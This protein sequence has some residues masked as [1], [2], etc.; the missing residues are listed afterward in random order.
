MRSLLVLSLLLL[1]CGDDDAMTPM[2]GGGGDAAA[3]STD[4]ACDDGLFCNGLETCA[5]GVCAPGDAPC[6]GACD[7]AAE[8][9]SDCADADG[10]GHADAAC[11]GD[12]CDDTDLNRYPGNEEVCD[13]DDVDEDCDPT[14]FGRRD[15]DGDDST[16]DACCNEGHCG[17]DCDDNRAGIS[18]T[19][20]ETCNGLDDDCDG[21]VDE[22]VGNTFYEDRDGDGF[23]AAGGLTSMECFPPDG[24][25]DND[26]DCND[27]ESGINPGVGEACDAAMVDENC[28]DIINPPSLCACTPGDEPR[29]CEREGVCAMG[30]EMCLGGM[31]GECSIRPMAE[32]CDGLDNDCNG[33]VDDGFL[34]SDDETRDCVVCGQAGVQTCRPGCA[35]FGA[36]EAT[37]LCND[38]DDDSDGAIDEDFDCRVGTTSACTNTCGNA[39]TALCGGACTAGACTAA[40]S[41]DYC[42]DDAD[43]TTDDETAL[44]T[45]EGV[46]DPRVCADFGVSGDATCSGSPVSSSIALVEPGDD[47]GA[48][49]IDDPQALGYREYDFEFQ[50]SLETSFT[51]GQHPRGGVAYMLSDEPTVRGNRFGTTANSGLPNRRGVAVEHQFHPGGSAT[52]RVRVLNLDGRGGVD[53]VIGCAISS[54]TFR[55]DQ[56]E[57]VSMNVRMRYTPANSALGRTQATLALFACNASVDSSCAP[58]TRLGCEGVGVTDFGPDTDLWAGVTAG[59]TSN[60]PYATYHSAAATMT[61]AGRCE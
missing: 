24:F 22:G 34:C 49:W 6:A 2:D 56:G 17:D 52:D 26:E 55:V 35:G 41:C 43:G 28:D 1:A 51:P 21:A 32:T 25:A 4:M 19:G 10:D 9:C 11:G 40:E 47:V 42:D 16:S 27:D 3:C 20:T 46:H 45:L 58:T 59:F 7:E 53:E 23:G 15:I 61:A 33:V 13:A 18:P 8:R 12:D 60:A 57:V 36:C 29:P 31:W 37:E 50:M 5:E 39:G 48:A 44:A 38:C 14:T 30:N 54:G